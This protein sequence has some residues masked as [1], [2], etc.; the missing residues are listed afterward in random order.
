MKKIFTIFWAFML[1]G[2]ASMT[3]TSYF[4]TLYEVKEDTITDING[5]SV[6]R[7]MLIDKYASM[8]TGNESTSI[9]SIPEEYAIVVETESPS[10]RFIDEITLRT[11]SGVV[12]LITRQPTRTVI[13]AQRLSERLIGVIP[14]RVI[15]EIKNTSTLAIQYKG[16]FV[17]L[18]SEAVT[19][20]KNF[21][22][23]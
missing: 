9:M 20:I 7:R 10:W 16:R 19:S 17:E 23:K 8:S 15:E 5:T 6:V 13:T 1:I 2:C 22:N 12:N 4:G 14:P 3:S 21:V 18:P 11:D